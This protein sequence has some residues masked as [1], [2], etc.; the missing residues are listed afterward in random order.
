MHFR[1]GVADRE[2]GE[3]ARGGAIVYVAGCCGSLSSI[4]RSDG[5]KVGWSSCG[6]KYLFCPSLPAHRLIPPCSVGTSSAAKP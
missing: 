3:Q 6:I 5:W 4:R 1:S 2:A